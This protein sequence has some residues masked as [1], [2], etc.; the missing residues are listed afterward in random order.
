MK[1]LKQHRRSWAF[2]FFFFFPFVFYGYAVGG[3]RC[4]G[5]NYN[6]A[7]Q[8][9]PFQTQYFGDDDD[10]AAKAAAAAACGADKRRQKA[11]IFAVAARSD[12]K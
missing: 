10:A 8:K 12:R 11:M 7:G 3:R 9:R 2:F 6:L 4:C 5:C 1:V